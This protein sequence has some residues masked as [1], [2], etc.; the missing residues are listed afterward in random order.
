[1]SEQV[2]FPERL[3]FLR[4]EKR[5]TPENFA[6]MLDSHRSTIVRYEKGDRFPSFETLIRMASLFSVST[7]YL[8]GITDRRGTEN[9]LKAR[10]I[11][12]V[13]AQMRLRE[14][15][16]ETQG[17]FPLFELDREGDLLFVR[18]ESRE[19]MPHYAPKDIWV[20][21]TDVQPASGDQVL[22]RRNG[23]VEMKT[24]YQR[25]NGVILVGVV[26]YASPEWVPQWNPEAVVG[27]LTH[28]IHSMKQV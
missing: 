27:I 2:R 12:S 20:V 5:W 8:L 13:K 21:K 7:D 6:G 9:S 22:L 15:N 1:M 3:R 19:Y 16:L 28:V 4:L 24:F 23:K 17:S 25:P 11:V 10:V 18:L 26:S 14:G